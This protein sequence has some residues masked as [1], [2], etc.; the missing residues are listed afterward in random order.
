MLRVSSLGTT[1]FIADLDGERIAR[2][3]NIESL[4]MAVFQEVPDAV[5]Q[6]VISG[7]G[8]DIDLSTQE[9]Y[10]F[11]EALTALHVK[12]NGSDFYEQQDE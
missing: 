7:Q 2:R 5:E 8:V 12:E 11:K 3:K 4:A 9:A 1:S 10:D 6:Y